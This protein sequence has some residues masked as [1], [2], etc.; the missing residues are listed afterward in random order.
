MEVTTAKGK[1]AQF[2]L[3]ADD[4][5]R[6]MDAIRNDQEAAQATLVQNEAII[7]GIES[8]RANVMNAFGPYA[9]Q[10]LTAIDRERNW[11]EKPVGTRK[12]RSEGEADLDP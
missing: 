11:Q 8:R 1:A 2:K 4:K 12:L 10:V 5:K 6:Q 3:D 9:V 7:R